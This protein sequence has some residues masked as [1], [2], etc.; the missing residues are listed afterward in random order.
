MLEIN[1]KYEIKSNNREIWKKRDA[2]NRLLNCRG[3]D[4]LIRIQTICLPLLPLL[5]LSQV[6]LYWSFVRVCVNERWWNSP[7]NAA[8]YILFKGKIAGR[9][10][11]KSCEKTK[12]HEEAETPGEKRTA[13][14]VADTIG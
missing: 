5:L 8:R 1:Y 3:D 11:K 14:A 9:N 12:S 13:T 4:L 6:Y 7:Q 2:R 10:W